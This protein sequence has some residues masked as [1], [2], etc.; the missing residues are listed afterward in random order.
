MG[1][2]FPDMP[3][4]VATVRGK[5]RPEKG[6]RQLVREACKLGPCWYEMGKV[7]PD[8]QNK[9]VINL[10][11]HVHTS[12]TTHS[13]E[14]LWETARVRLRRDKGLCDAVK[15]T[16]ILNGMAGVRR[17]I[18]SWMPPMVVYTVGVDF[19]MPE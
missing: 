17:L 2:G 6:A 3:I 8:P 1:L 7:R 10:D 4:I 11:L 15:S 16:F 9:G 19:G 12:W 13:P 14:F 18:E 5:R